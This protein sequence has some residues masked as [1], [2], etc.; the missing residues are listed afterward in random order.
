MKINVIE[1]PNCTWEL[2]GDTF[3]CTHDEREVEEFVQDHLGFQGHYQTEHLGYVC[4]DP[5]CGEV[6][7]G[8]PEE[9]AIDEDYEYEQYRDRQG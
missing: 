9:D 7:E 3:F 8:S 2:E 6:L 1:I 5:D 4:A